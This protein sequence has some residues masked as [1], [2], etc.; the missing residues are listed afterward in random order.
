[1]ERFPYPCNNRICYYDAV[2]EKNPIDLYAFMS[3]DTEE[4]T[5]NDDSFNITFLHT[6]IRNT[7]TVIIRIR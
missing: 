3:R 1:M 4:N 6:R 2:T 5:K 7:N